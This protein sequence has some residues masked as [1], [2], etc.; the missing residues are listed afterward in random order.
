MICGFSPTAS[1][2]VWTVEVAV[3]A[4]CAAD[5]ARSPAKDI[6]I[7]SEQAYMRYKPRMTIGYYIMERRSGQ[8]GYLQKLVLPIG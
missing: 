8:L 1:G 7:A 2:L 5:F 4:T 3:G 6:N